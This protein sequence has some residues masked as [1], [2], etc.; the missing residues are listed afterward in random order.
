MME[1]DDRW[2]LVLGTHGR[3]GEQWAIW[4][5]VFSPV[6]ARWLSEANLGSGNRR[7]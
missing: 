4:Q 2:E 1:G 6:G 5:A 7:D 3:S